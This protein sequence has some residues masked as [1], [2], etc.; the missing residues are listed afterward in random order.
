MSRSGDAGDMRVAVTSRQNP[1]VRRA[2]A[3]RDGKD[4]ELIFVE[5]LRL[6]EEAA[7]ASLTIELL[8]F[9]PSFAESARGAQL[10]DA[11][12]QTGALLVPLS[13]NVLGAMADTKTPQ[14]IVLLARRPPTDYRQFE[15]LFRRGSNTSQLVIVL[16][17]A[18][19]PSNAGA[20]LRVA[21]AAGATAVIATQHTVDIFSPKSLRGSMGS[22][23][24]LPIWTGASLDEALRWCAESGIKTVSTSPSAGLSYTE[25]DWTASLAVV[26]GE[27]GGGLEAGE[28]AATGATIKIPMRAVVESLN[29]ATALAVVLYEAAR[30]RGF[31]FPT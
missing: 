14:G 25:I 15:K 28:L 1:L 7:S 23:F 4:K 29:V 22:A 27:E 9:T 18:A 8:F 11:I 12:S 3:V 21:E 30:Q 19:N 20:M 17:G 6:C 31:T 16:H 13:E 5:G 24:R 2:R 10:L 26:V